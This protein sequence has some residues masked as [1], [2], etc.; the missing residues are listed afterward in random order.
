MWV[1]YAQEDGAVLGPSLDVLMSAMPLWDR[2]GSSCNRE[3]MHNTL[4]CTDITF[5][6]RIWGALRGL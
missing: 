5:N 1:P 6:S 3:T 4:H 2:T